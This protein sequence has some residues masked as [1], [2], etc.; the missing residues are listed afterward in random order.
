[1]RELNFSAPQLWLRMQKQ[2][3]KE[4]HKRLELPHRSPARQ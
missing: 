1:M 4:E 2:E 3:E